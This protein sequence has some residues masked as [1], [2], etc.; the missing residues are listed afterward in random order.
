MARTDYNKIFEATLEDIRAKGAV[1]SVLLHSC[2]A[3]CSSACLQRLAQDFS[4]TVFYYNPNLYPE[5]EYHHR[6]SE[7]ERFVKLFP[8]AHPI[9]FIEGDYDRSAFFDAIKGLEDIPEGGERCFACYRMRLEATAG[10]AAR[11]GFD[12]FTTTLS[13]S[14]LKNAGVLNETGAE[15]SE[16]YGVPYLFSDFKKKD[17]FK[18]STE[19]SAQYGMYR[20]DYCGCE[21]SLAER[22]A[23]KEGA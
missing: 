19:L 5:E 16:K 23:H 12:F 8:A 1:P 2:C 18:R 7:Q 21:F 9:S 17:G 20:Q 13:I 14:P 10:L 3:P 4:V 22:R 11:R 6:A 15:L